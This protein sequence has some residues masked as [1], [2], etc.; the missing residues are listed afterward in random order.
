MKLKFRYASYLFLVL[1]V[2]I[3]FASAIVFFIENSS[4]IPVIIIF[5]LLYPTTYYLGR[6][7]TKVFLLLA[8]LKYIK[9]NNGLITKDQYEDFLRG[10]ARKGHAAV[11]IEV[12]LKEII[13]TLESEELVEIEGDSIILTVL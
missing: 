2:L 12:Y 3:L 5:L 7:M 13:A 10:C 1:V 6:K 4:Y 9:K 8:C 11:N